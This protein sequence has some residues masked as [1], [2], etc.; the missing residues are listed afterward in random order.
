ML[1]AQIP[2]DLL[3]AGHPDAA[4]QAMQRAA[5]FFQVPAHTHMHTNTQKHKH[6]HKHVYTHTNTHTHTHTTQ[7]LL[8]AYHALAN[9]E[10]DVLA[11][12][13]LRQLWD[14]MVCLVTPSCFFSR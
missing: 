3:A 14:H 12:A 5:D 1:R 6:T 11:K 4:L 8:N 13:L 2:E 7:Q 9:D 10:N